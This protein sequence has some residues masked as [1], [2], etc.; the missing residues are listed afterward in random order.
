M[1]GEKSGKF[2]RID[3]R[4]RD[5]SADPVHDERAHQEQQPLAHFGEAGDIP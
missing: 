5:E 4:N 1:G 3:A 2:G